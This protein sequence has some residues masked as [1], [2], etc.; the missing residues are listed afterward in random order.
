MK[1]YISVAKHAL[2][3]SLPEVPD[4]PTLLLPRFDP[5]LLAHK[6]KSIWVDAG[7]KG[8]VWTKN[9]IIKGTVL[10]KGRIEGV[11]KVD[12][13][14][15]LVDMF[16]EVGDERGVIVEEGERVLKFLERT[17]GMVHFI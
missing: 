12:G 1:S 17:G 10:V 14:A 13:N 15:I 2:I 9:G 3:E 16:E 5:L 4:I 8:E 11:W 7:R 6:D